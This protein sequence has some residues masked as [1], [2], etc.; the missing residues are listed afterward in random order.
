MMCLPCAAGG[1][2]EKGERAANT[3]GGRRALAEHADSVRHP[4]PHEGGMEWVKEG[5]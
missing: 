3:H 2:H 4:R 1:S 5:C